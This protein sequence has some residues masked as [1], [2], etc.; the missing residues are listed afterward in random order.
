MIAPASPGKQAPEER[1]LAEL[2]D[3]ASRSSAPVP[4]LPKDI[5][6]RHSG[7]TRGTGPRADAIDG[8]MG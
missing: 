2:G 6:R 5:L 4:M 1:G 8:S 7:A 3:S